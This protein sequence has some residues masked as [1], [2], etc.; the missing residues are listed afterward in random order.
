M[1]G[2]GDAD[3]AT[4]ALIARMLHEDAQYLNSSGYGTV[5]AGDG[6]DGDD[7]GDSDWDGQEKRG[8]AKRRKT[9]TKAKKS[10]TEKVKTKRT[11]PQ[12]KKHAAPQKAKK[13]TASPSDDANTAGLLKGKWNEEEEKLFVEA[14][15]LYGRDYAAGAKH[16]GTRTKHNFASHAQKYFIKLYI[17]NKPLP[18]K[19][20]ESGL[21]FTLS[22]KPLD[23]ESATARAYG[24]KKGLA[25]AALTAK[26]NASDKTNA[27]TMP[28]AVG[29]GDKKGYK[30]PR[31]I[32]DELLAQAKARGDVLGQK[33]HGGKSNL[34]TEKPKPRDPNYEAWAAAMAQRAEASKAIHKAQDE[35]SRKGEIRELKRKAEERERKA[36]ERK[37][38]AEK[39]IEAR[40]AK[41]AAMQKKA[42]EK[43]L[44]RRAELGIDANGR[45]EYSRSRS[46]RRAAT[47]YV[48][49][50][51]TELQFVECGVYSNASAIDVQ[52]FEV[53]VHSSVHFLAD[54]HAHLSTAEVMGFL[55]GKWDRE[56]KLI[57]VT[58][59]YPG[60]SVN[61]GST[62]C[63]MDPLVEVMLKEKIT[64]QGLQV[65]G[66]YHSH[67]TFEPIPSMCD[68]DTQTNYQ[69]L[70]HDSATGDDPFIALIVTPFDQRL[71]SP[72]SQMHWF[73]VDAPGTLKKPMT[74]QTDTVVD[75]KLADTVRE[76][77]KELV[78]RSSTSSH[79][80]E[81]SQ[82]W[83]SLASSESGETFTYR[84]KF[85]ASLLSRIPPLVGAPEASDGGAA[86]KVFIH[87]LVEDL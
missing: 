64:S 18:P 37:R 76:Y 73:H 1:S 78:L 58:A 35:R 26:E 63:E 41:K 50:P 82:K 85:K 60:R 48:V 20:A 65:V 9:K 66:W 8:R 68:V 11:L 59:A 79:T 47:K 70:F 29:D 56:K 38:A 53:K 46:R 72:R 13:S 14:L 21:G 22:G 31:E 3:A 6:A 5:Y 27:E 75:S 33:T 67:P 81:Y 34:A 49:D 39:K 51:S 84:E 15:H 4:S 10:A 62:E 45:T 43:S 77:A 80:V 71:P 16:V 52:P 36:E 86:D 12:E 44:K 23:P 74:V 17:Q 55:A 40:K 2:G 25:R 32:N 54:L 24:V 19:V 61:E 69:A 30:T 7:D 28:G 42:R 87:D 83:Y 57:E